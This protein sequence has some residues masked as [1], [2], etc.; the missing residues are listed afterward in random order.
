[1]SV[2]QPISESVSRLLRIHIAPLQDSNLQFYMG[3]FQLVF[4]QNLLLPLL[5]RNDSASERLTPLEALYKNYYLI[6]I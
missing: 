4:L 1:M 2:S 3:V 6:T 5:F